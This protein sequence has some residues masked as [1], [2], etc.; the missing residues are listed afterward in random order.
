MESSCLKNTNVA[1][2]FVTLVELVNRELINDGNNGV[3]ITNN[4]EIRR[5][6]CGGKKSKSKVDKSNR[7]SNYSFNEIS[8]ETNENNFDIHNINDR[9]HISDSGKNSNKKKNKKEDKCF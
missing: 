5:S 6:K 3:K 9:S 8:S 4:R 7:N 2:A 1:N